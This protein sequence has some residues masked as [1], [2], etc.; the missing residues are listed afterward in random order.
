MRAT[1]SMVLAVTLF[2]VPITQV[3]AQAGQQA[4][5]TVSDT[6]TTPPACIGVPDVEDDNAALL[7]LAG[8]PSPVATDSLPYTPPYRHISTGA[9][10]TIVL[11]AALVV[12]AIVV[13]IYCSANQGCHLLGWE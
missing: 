13:V 6:T 10:V 4:R 1:I 11:S 7:W 9:K 2:T 8:D 3:V 5:A 12:V